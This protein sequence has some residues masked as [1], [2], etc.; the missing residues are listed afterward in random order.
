[1]NWFHIQQHE[2]CRGDGHE[3]HPDYRSEEESVEFDD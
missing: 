2:P 1:M 3:H